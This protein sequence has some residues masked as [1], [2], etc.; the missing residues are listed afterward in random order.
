FTIRYCPGGLSRQEI[1]SAYYAY[2]DLHD[3]CEKYDPAKLAD[4]WNTVD[5]E[6]IFFISNP[7]LGLW[8]YRGRFS[9]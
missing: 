8:A 6:E 5:G 9:Q 4:G 2:G 7:A 3:Y 1:E